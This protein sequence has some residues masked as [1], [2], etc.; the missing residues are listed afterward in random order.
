MSRAFGVVFAQESGILGWTEWTQAVADERAF[1]IDIGGLPCAARLPLG[2][3]KA[4][5]ALRKGLAAPAGEA[6]CETKV[7]VDAVD[8]DVRDFLAWLDGVPARADRDRSRSPR[9]PRGDREDGRV[10][11][12]ACPAPEGPERAPAGGSRQGRAKGP[13]PAP[14]PAGGDGRRAEQPRAGGAPR[15][16]VKSGAEGLVE[17][18][19]RPRGRGALA[20]QVAGDPAELQAAVT[21]IRQSLYAP[22]TWASHASE[23]SLY[24]RV[25]AAARLVPYPLKRPQLEAFCAVLKRAWFR[26]ATQYVGAVVRQNRLL[27]HTL[28]TNTL[29]YRTMLGRALTR[30]IGDAKRVLPITALMLRAMRERVRGAKAVFVWRLMAVQWFFLLR[31]AEILALTPDDI[32]FVPAATTGGVEVPSVQVRLVTGKTN[33]RAITV[34]RT[35]SCVCVSERVHCTV[36]DSLCPF[37]VLQ[38]LKVAQPHAPA[39][40]FVPCLGAAAL[41]PAAYLDHVRRCVGLLGVPLRTETEGNLYGTHSL[42]RGGAQALAQ[43]G[44]ALEDIKLFGRWMSAAVELYLLD[45]PMRVH[46]REL[47][48]SMVH[49]VRGASGDRTHE[50]VILRPGVRLAL[51][52][53]VPVGSEPPEVGLVWEV[54]DGEREASPSGWI[55]C[56]VIASPASS[57]LG[58]NPPGSLVVVPPVPVTAPQQW[59]WNGR[60]YG[61]APVGGGARVRTVVWVVQLE[62]FDWYVLS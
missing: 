61:L 36:G 40:Q 7:Q 4:C 9:C 57:S 30:G 22:R 3:A 2:F 42:R 29:E 49:G 38:A 32:T 25:M 53:F 37:H 54:A 24:E 56:E 59:P 17:G 48:A 60:I 44:W 13:P 39:A 1:W 15:L 50:P 8:A 43:A 46:A 23:V 16:S 5:A 55:T 52:L 20:V 26:S 6:R 51:R 62:L 28:D 14:G 31:E 35:L 18:G 47:A 27:G 34:T 33:Q 45:V 11:M 10:P 21:A 19:P 12:L 41:G 58:T